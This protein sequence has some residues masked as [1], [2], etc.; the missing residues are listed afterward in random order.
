MGVRVERL[1]KHQDI[2]C[3]ILCPSNGKW[4]GTRCFAAPQGKSINASST[5]EDISPNN[6]FINNEDSPYRNPVIAES[7][8]GGCPGSEMCGMARCSGSDCGDDIG[9]TTAL[10]G[11]LMSR[12]CD[13]IS[14]LNEEALELGSE[15]CEDDNSGM[16]EIAL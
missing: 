1:V 3:A 14:E 7:G 10:D 6:S 16:S 12:E 11:R 15:S 13:D 2:T 8:E 5:N 4:K 9:V